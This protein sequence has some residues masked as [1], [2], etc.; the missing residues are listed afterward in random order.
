MWVCIYAD[1]WM[2]WGCVSLHFIG[3][4]RIPSE[5]LCISVDGTP[6]L[7]SDQYIEAYNHF[8]DHMRHEFEPG[9]APFTAKEWLQTHFFIP[10]D[11]TPDLSAGSDYN[12]ELS[13]ASVSLEIKFDKALEENVMLI[14][15][16]EI[17][18]VL[19]LDKNAKVTISDVAN[20]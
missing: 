9:R 16:S 13:S 7:V 10:I 15:V 1:G 8:L 4:R 6:D 14:S 12:T 5:A 11:L 17:P 19:T 20:R 3:G 18:K 2:G